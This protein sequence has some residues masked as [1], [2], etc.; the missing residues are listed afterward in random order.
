[1]WAKCKSITL[2]YPNV[3]ENMVTNLPSWAEW[4]GVRG[5]LL[6]FQP[7]LNA[8]Q[9][10]TSWHFLCP[11]FFLNFVKFSVTCCVKGFLYDLYVLIPTA[12]ADFICMPKRALPSMQEI[13]YFRCSH[14]ILYISQEWCSGIFLFL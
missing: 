5:N 6:N 14:V 4:L 12:Y 9:Q 7:D 1:M 10:C 3:L 2:K 11:P 8:L 13:N